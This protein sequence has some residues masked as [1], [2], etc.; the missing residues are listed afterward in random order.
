MPR[1]AGREGGSTSAVSG[2]T[3]PAHTARIK[4]IFRRDKHFCHECRF[5]CTLSVCTN[6]DGTYFRDHSTKTLNGSENKV[7]L[8]FWLELHDSLEGSGRGHWVSGG[9][10]DVQVSRLQVSQTQAWSTE[11]SVASL[12]HGAAQSCQDQG[13]VGEGGGDTFRQGTTSCSVELDSL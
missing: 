10:E 6:K 12:R 9:H 13:G 3:S 1:S 7:R 2:E 11:F 4:V 8:S 5:C